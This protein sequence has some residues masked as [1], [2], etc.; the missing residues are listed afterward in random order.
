MPF[1]PHPKPILYSC[2]QHTDNGEKKTYRVTGIWS[3]GGAQYYQ[4]VS[5][6]L[7]TLTGSSRLNVPFEKMVQIIKDEILKPI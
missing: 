4:V 2:W 6:E 3:K 7:T 5:Y 1:Y